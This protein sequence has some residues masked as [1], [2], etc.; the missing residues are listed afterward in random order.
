MKAEAKGGDGD[1]FGFSPSSPDPATALVLRPGILLAGGNERQTAAEKLQRLR[2]TGPVTN[3]ITE[4]QVITSSLDWDD[5]AL[6][7]KYLEGLKPEIRIVCRT[8]R[9]ILRLLQLFLVR[10]TWGFPLPRFRLRILLHE[11]SFLLTD[12]SLRR[13]DLTVRL[14]RCICLVH[15]H[16]QCT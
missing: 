1:D 16:Y 15:E 13:K 2:Q 8:R 6:E 4:F 9:L 5:E 3:Y 14:A 12:W 7:D 11:L 10:H